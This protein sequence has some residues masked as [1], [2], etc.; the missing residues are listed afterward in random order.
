MAK[1]HTGLIMNFSSVWQKHLILGVRFFLEIVF[2]IS[3]VNLWIMTFLNL[4]LFCSILLSHVET[5]MQMEQD[6][7][8]ILSTL[9]VSEDIALSQTLI[10]DHN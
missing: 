1:K 6:V 4:I 5:A 8:I 10:S 2:T 7:G 9:T 3:D